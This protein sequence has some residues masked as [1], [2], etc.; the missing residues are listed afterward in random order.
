MARTIF[1]DF[2]LPKKIR[3]RPAARRRS[4]RSL[5]SASASRTFCRI[6]RSFLGFLCSEHTCSIWATWGGTAVSSVARV[7]RADFTGAT[8]APSAGCA[9]LL[10]PPAPFPSHSPPTVSTPSP[11][12]GLSAGP[13]PLSPPHVVTEARISAR[14]SGTHR[15]THSPRLWGSVALK[16]HVCRSG[17]TSAQIADTCSSKPSWSSRSHSSRTRET[18]PRSEM[19]RDARRSRRRPGVATTMCGGPSSSRDLICSSLSHPP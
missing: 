9:A 15:F 5:R 7:G 10:S 1:R 6:P 13:L 18:T 3:T 2:I 17:L 4:D 16:R 11:S 14:G 19:T 8:A 12:L